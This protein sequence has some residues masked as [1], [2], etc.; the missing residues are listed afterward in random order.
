MDAVGF[1]ASHD[2]VFVYRKTDR[3]RVKQLAKEVNAEQFNF[4]DESLGKNYRRRSLR[5]EGSESRRK[6]R[7]SMWY[8]IQAQ[9]VLMCGQ[10]SLMG[11]K[12]VGVGKREY[13][14]QLSPS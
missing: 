8:S 6:D 3:F 14:S 11:R 5:K 4:F 2:H 7:P 13:I 10:S 12:D 9:M 1:S